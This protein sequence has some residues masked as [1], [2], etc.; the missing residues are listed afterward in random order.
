MGEHR[1][2]APKVTYGINCKYLSRVDGM[3]TKQRVGRSW[4]RLIALLAVV[5][6]AFG[7]FSCAKPTAPKA[8][9]SEPAVDPNPL[10]GRLNEV[11]PPE[12][13]QLLKQII[14]AYTPQVR[15]LSPRPGE[16][17]EDT[18]VSVRV[19]VRGL[20]LF[21]KRNLRN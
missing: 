16:I 21:Q 10:A 2:K 11:S 15:I 8:L 19:Q 20:P 13:L 12:P 1:C 17:I 6:L 4:Q 18:S 7:T 3:G 9:M 14:D 5:V